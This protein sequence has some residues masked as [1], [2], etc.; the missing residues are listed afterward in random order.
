MKAVIMAGG[1]GTRFWPASRESRPKQFLNITGQ[2]TMLQQTMA[3][4]DP[5]LK[6]EDM[7]IVCAEEFLDNVRVQAPG[8][9]PSRVMLEPLARGTAACI[10]YAALALRRESPDAVMAVLPAD[11]LVTNVAEFHRVLRAARELAADGWLV[12][13]GIQATHPATGYGYIERGNLIGVVGGRAAYQV[14]KFEEK[15]DA[16]RA[17]VLV[18]TGRHEWNSGMFVWSVS[19]ILER[20]KALMPDLHRALEEIDRDWSNPARHKEIFEPLESVS[21]DVGVL[22]GSEKVAVVPCDLGWSDVGN[23]CS[24]ENILPQDQHGNVANGTYVQIDSR[25]CIVQTTHGKLVALVGVRDLIVVETPDAVL[26]CDRERGEE[27]RRVVEILRERGLNE[28][29]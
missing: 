25:G 8:F 27:V 2:R 9:D 17:R 21:I 1:K 15:P 13:F 11:H 20:I 24:L 16:E 10:G 6:P 12:T 23:W 28:F 7:V 4:L 14:R 3:R 18:E 26:V 29:L 22:E 19:A 5:L